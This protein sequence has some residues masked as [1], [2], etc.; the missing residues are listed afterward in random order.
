MDSTQKKK[1][2]MKKKQ[3]EIDINNNSE[4]ATPTT[5]KADWKNATQ[6]PHTEH[7]TFQ[8]NNEWNDWRNKN[9]QKKT[10]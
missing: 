6:Y 2:K 8:N 9:T 5:A 7:R 3:E 1:E 10:Y 4:G